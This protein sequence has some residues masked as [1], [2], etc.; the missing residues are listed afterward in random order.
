MYY[1]LSVGLG[2][3]MGRAYLARDHSLLVVKPYFIV[4][5]I[6]LLLGLGLKGG[7]HY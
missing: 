5:K 4:L 7:V 1:S 2:F 3:G 6:A